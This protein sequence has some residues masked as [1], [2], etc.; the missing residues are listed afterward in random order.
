MLNT[1]DRVFKRLTEAAATAMQEHA[2]V[3]SG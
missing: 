2:L 1:P 3:G